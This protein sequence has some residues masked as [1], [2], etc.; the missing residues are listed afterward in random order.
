LDAMEKN[1]VRHIVF[2]STVAIY[3]L[4]KVNPSEDKA[5]DPFNHYGKSKWQAEE[6]LQEWYSSHIDRNINII[7]PTVIFGENNRGNVYHLLRQSA[8]GKFMMIGKG[9]NKKSMAYIGNVV[10]FI[11]FLIEERQK[12]G[13]HV[14]NYVD[15]PDFTTNDLVRHTGEI[16]EKKIP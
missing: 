1:D 6:L 5:A 4:N 3:G 2:T 13:Y 7:R 8:S 10:A 15:K 16:L 12:V 14:Y 9:N 11:R